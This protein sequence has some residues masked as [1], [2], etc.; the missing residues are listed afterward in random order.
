MALYRV[1][2][3]MGHNGHD[4]IGVGQFLGIGYR[5]GSIEMKQQSCVKGH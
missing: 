1:A 5:N 2:Y 3:S 4:A